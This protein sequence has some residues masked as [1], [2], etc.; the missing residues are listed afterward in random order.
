MRFSNHAEGPKSSLYNA[1]MANLKKVY[2]EIKETLD[3]RSP[4]FVAK[5]SE[6]Y[7]LK[8]PSGRILLLQSVPMPIGLHVVK[9]PHH[10]RSGA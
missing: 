7:L 10:F 5:E 6:L 1:S 2:W 3:A 9:S 4:L 8:V